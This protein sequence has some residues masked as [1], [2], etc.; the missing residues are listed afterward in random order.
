MTINKKSVG[1][2]KKRILIR[3]PNWIGDQVLAY[4]FF[5]FLR[6]TYPD[7]H[8]AVACVH[9]VQS[10]QFRNLIDE[11]FILPKAES[12]GLFAQWQALE[13][14]A[15]TLQQAGKWD[16]GICL[17]NSFSS[18]WLLFRSGVKERR[19]YQSDGRTFLLTHGL[20]QEP[21]GVT[22]RTEAYLRLLTE[23]KISRRVIEEFWGVPP[24]HEMDLGIE[25][26]L[27]EFDADQAWPSFQVFE[28]PTE[29]Y[30]VLAPG[31]AA[32][33][34]RWPIDRFATL[35]RKITERT[36]WKGVIVGGAA[37][38]VLAER[39]LEYGGLKL[40][41]WTARGT[42]P[43]YW[44][45]FRQ[46]QFSVCNDSGLAHVAS[47]CGSPVFITWGAGHPSRTKPIGPG[48]VNLILNPVE[49]W[50][51]E[52]NSCQ[53]PPTVEPYQCLKG[54]DVDLIWKE[55]QAEIRI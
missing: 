9:W 45:I 14:A 19:G 34:R 12:S 53:L 42:V 15:K 39:L 43:A 41:N 31:S 18:A 49:C 51:C 48:K 7:A 44:K 27:S 33:S 3:A 50:P 32:D 4:P 40:E 21:K 22:H 46:A 23:R 37:E 55:I 6:E 13:K 25:G 52:R 1:Q 24:T 8:I 17:P 16:L 26:V 2:A 38:A 47:L 10:L 54:I 30:W 35:A 5:H 36:G 29:P 20:K 28:P 11:V